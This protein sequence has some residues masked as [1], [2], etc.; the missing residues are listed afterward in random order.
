M[1]NLHRVLSG[2]YTILHHDKL[3][4]KTGVV[5]QR[6]NAKYIG[7][8][9]LKTKDG[10]VNT[11]VAIFYQKKIPTQ[12]KGIASHYFGLYFNHENELM[13]TNA[14]SATQHK[15][16]GVLNPLTKEVLYSAYRH[17][18]QTYDN[19]MADGGPEYTRS[20]HSTLIEFEIKKDRLEIVDVK[21]T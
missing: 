21:R 6:Y 1:E 3:G 11:P 2:E 17:D 4:I 9:S 10:W 12:Y 16:V 15:W 7:E 13:I 19:M 18:F 20:S 5:E 14:L 8:F